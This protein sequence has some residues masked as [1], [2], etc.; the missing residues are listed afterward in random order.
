VVEQ[1]AHDL[2]GHLPV[3][4]PGGEGVPPLVGGQVHRLAVLV[5]DLAAG[6]PAAQLLAVDGG[7]QGLA[8]VRVAGG[9][10]EQ[11]GNTAR[12]AGK[13]PALLLLELAFEAFVDWHQRLTLQLVVDI[14]QIG[15]AIAGADDAVQRQP[16]GVTDAQATPDQQRGEQPPGR[17]GPALQVAGVLD[18]GHDLF[19]QRPGAAGRR[20][21]AC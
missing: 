1:D 6:Q 13:H 17:I 19:G 16:G 9:L 15:G 21:R 3:D 18:L 8:A 20:A 14:A 12:P 2:L 7:A 4:Q 10:R 5:T 11:A